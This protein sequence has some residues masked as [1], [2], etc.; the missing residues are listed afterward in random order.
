MA[1]P[2]R[3]DPPEESNHPAPSPSQLSQDDRL[4]WAKASLRG[5]IIPQL[6][7]FAVS[8]CEALYADEERAP[9]IYG[10]RFRD[11]ANKLVKQRSLPW[12]FL[13][14]IEGCLNALLPPR[15]L[16]ENNGYRG[17]FTVI[18]EKCVV[19]IEH[20]EQFQV[21]RETNIEFAA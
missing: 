19:K 5:V 11:A 8:S 9:V 18:V 16:Q 1:K 17:V 7:K 20:K 2:S 21:T 15:A 10:M 14:A 6:I 13:D 12:P 4:K 3:P